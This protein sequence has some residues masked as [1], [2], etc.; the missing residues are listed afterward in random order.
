MSAAKTAAATVDAGTALNFRADWRQSQGGPIRQGE[1]LTINYDPQRLTS[2]RNYHDGMPAWDLFATVRF[3]PSG[4]TTSGN[5]I[6]HVGGHGVLDPPKPVPLTLR[7]PADATD[8]EMWF[9]NTSSMS[10]CS[11]FDSQFG[12]NYRFIVGQAGPAQPVMYR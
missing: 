9:W 5:L 10:C 3:S 1:L 2:C 8:T 11:E 7:V 6:Q 12:N 4:E